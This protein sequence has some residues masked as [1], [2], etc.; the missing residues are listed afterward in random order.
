MPETFDNR[1]AIKEGWDIGRTPN[2]RLVPVKAPS[3]PFPDDINAQDFVAFQALQGSDY[4][5]A[6]MALLRHDRQDEKNSSVFDT[7]MNSVCAKWVGELPGDGCFI[8]RCYGA[9]NGD[10]WQLQ[11]D[12]SS[13][14]FEDDD[15]AA[16]YVTKRADEG[17][18]YH[19]RVLRFLEIAQPN[20][21][22]RI[23]EVSAA[24][25][26]KSAAPAV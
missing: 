17:S 11:K 26:G 1:Q 19:R 12:D 16:V 20:E 3:S 18:E 24:A 15:E 13:A 25:A 14:A 21:A 10:T 4:H 5:A 2:D 7:I 6:A 22:K 23:A 8:S 9:A